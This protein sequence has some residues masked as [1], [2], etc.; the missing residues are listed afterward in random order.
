MDETSHEKGL[1]VLR[2]IGW[3]DEPAAPIKAADEEFWKLTVGH[4]FGDI[5][6]RTG[7]SLRDRELVTLATLIALDRARGLRPHLRN[8]ATL[9]IT[10]E[11][12]RE[13]IIQVMHYA[14]WSVG[15]HAIVAFR[16][17]LSERAAADV[18]TD[19]DAATP[20]KG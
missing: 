11:E 19:K 1:R 14:G 15:A 10:D 4:L 9:G 5:W 12:M 16:E 8:A 2:E 3:G 7:L 17:V 20:L 13:I 6:G 18:D